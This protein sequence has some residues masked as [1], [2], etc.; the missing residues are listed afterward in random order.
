[1]LS[2]WQGAAIQQ[3]YG[4]QLINYPNAS[5]DNIERYYLNSSIYDNSIETPETLTPYNGNHSIV[6]PTIGV[7]TFNDNSSKVTGR[8]YEGNLYSYYKIV[9]EKDITW[10]NAYLRYVARQSNSIKQPLAYNKVDPTTGKRFGQT[11][12]AYD[13]IYEDQI[14]TYINYSY[15]LVQ[16]LDYLID[17]T[18][19]IS[20]M[21]DVVKEQRNALNMYN[22]SQFEDDTNGD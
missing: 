12:Y 5:I 20:F 17:K 18:K 14:P 8:F 15:Q 19:M 10:D 7:G 4:N 22:S 9:N 2:S 3:I 13:F 11:Y 1:M 16:T 6:K 21:V